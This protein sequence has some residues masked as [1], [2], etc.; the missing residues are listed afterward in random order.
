MAKKKSATKKKSTRKKAAKKKAAKKTTATKAPATKRKPKSVASSLTSLGNQINKRSVADHGY[1]AAG[2][3]YSDI[4]DWAS[5]GCTP[6]DVMMWGG[7]PRGRIISI[8]G[9]PSQG[10]STLMESVFAQNHRIDGG[11]ILLM[12]ESCLDAQRMQREGVDLTTLLPLEIDT[13]EQGVFYMHDALK[14]RETFDSAWCAKHPLVIGW[15]TPSNA[16]EQHIFDNP[17]DTFGQGMAS[18]ARSV[19]SALR[20]IVPLAGRLNVTILLLF[21]QHQKIGPYAGKDIDCGG[22]PKFNASLRIQARQIERLVSP[23]M[24]DR[25]IGIISRFE[26]IKSKA[27]CP[28]F[29]HCETVI[30]AWDGMDNDASMFRFLRDV[31]CVDPCPTCGGRM[32]NS[33]R[34]AW[35]SDTWK[36]CETCNGSGEVYHL[37]DKQATNVC[38]EGKTS[39]GNA[40]QWR[41]IFGW[42]GEEKITTT[43]ADLG[44]ALDARPGL[45][46]WLAEQCWRRCSKPTPAIFHAVE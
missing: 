29:R 9:D 43:D 4:T 5:T 38:V 2:E 24:T 34:T 18:K 17:E 16:Q 11:N 31:P 41:Y 26:I 30:R 21:Q 23:T 1:E 33:D 46:T 8:E 14:Q 20:T 25:E 3:Y 32:A 12:S 6:L 27:A 10:K 19:R 15:D 13:F 44:A 45:R 37:I 36:T 22:G 40:T 28:P 7:L 42:P 39:G 35:V